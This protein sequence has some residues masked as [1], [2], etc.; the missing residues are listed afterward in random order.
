MGKVR[1]LSPTQTNVTRLTSKLICFIHRISHYQKDVQL[2]GPR[3]QSIIIYYISNDWIPSTDSPL[4]A[5][6]I[7]GDAEEWLSC[8]MRWISAS[9]GSLHVSVLEH[10]GQPHHMAVAYQSVWIQSTAIT[11]TNLPR[12]RISYMNHRTS[13]IEGA[14]K[15]CT[16][17]YV[18]CLSRTKLETSL[19]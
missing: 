8:Q 13:K 4:T 3:N 15:L 9:Y 2:S 19:W 7:I 18:L 6:Q 12:Q 5:F 11:R 10:L 16:I 1:I 17:R 14:L